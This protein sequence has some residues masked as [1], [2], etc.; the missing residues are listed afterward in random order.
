MKYTIL[1]SVFLVILFGCSQKNKLHARTVIQILN[2]EN[3]QKREKDS[4]Q[5]N[6]DIFLAIEL[7]RSDSVVLNALSRTQSNLS[8]Q[9][10]KENIEVK[11]LNYAAQTI[12]VHFFSS[13]PHFSTIFLD[14]LVE[15]MDKRFLKNKKAPAELQLIYLNG[16]IETIGQRL[17]L[18]EKQ[19]GEGRVNDSVI[20]FRNLQKTYYILLEKRIEL[21]IA[22]AGIVS[23]IYIMQKSEFIK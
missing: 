9:E 20:L 5:K 1:I 11:I 19:I 13:D 3:G 17:P 22:N 7:L 12:E 21:A 8:A 18:L 15:E 10:V 6:R 14:L 2:D 16:E 4:L 23:S